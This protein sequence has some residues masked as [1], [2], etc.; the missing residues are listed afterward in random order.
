MQGE[1]HGTIGILG[2]GVDGRGVAEFLEGIDD[3]DRVVV[4]DDAMNNEQLTLLR[5]G[6][7]GQVM[8][9]NGRL[10]LGE[11]LDGVDLLFRSPGFPLNHDLV[12]Q[13]KEKNI[14]ITSSTAQVLEKFEGITVGV[15]GSNGKTTCVALIEEFLKAEF[16]EDQ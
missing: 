6:S 16:G 2:F 9:N 13:A 4:F 1:L 5:Q 14:P 3:V 7:A 10:F 15:T 8:N 11:N 12:K